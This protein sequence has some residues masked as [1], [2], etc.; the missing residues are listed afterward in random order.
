MSLTS[1]SCPRFWLW[2]HGLFVDAYAGSIVGW[3]CSLHHD[4]ELVLRALCRACDLRAHQ[5]HSLW[6]QTI[7]HSDAGSAYTAL[8]FGESLLLAGLKPSIGSVGDALSNAL[9]ETTIGLYKTECI[10][11]APRFAP[12]R[13]EHWLTSRKSLKHGY[14]ATTQS[15]S[16]TV[17][18]GVL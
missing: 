6:G 1:P 14:T 8:R 9:A 11:R 12:G 3:A 17:L 13:L 10:R 5:G 15:A 16:C 2:L 7:H 18:R 4:T